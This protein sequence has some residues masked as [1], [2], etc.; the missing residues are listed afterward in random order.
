MAAGGEM[1]GKK[2]LK[3]LIDAVLARS[4]LCE[5]RLSL[6][7]FSIVKGWHHA[8]T[9]VCLSYLPLAR[10]RGAPRAFQSGRPSRRSAPRANGTLEGGH[11][12]LSGY[13][14]VGNSLATL[15]Q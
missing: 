1:P 13:R 10:C 4:T 6:G 8:L 7:F 15:H 2:D 11:A 9:V 3:R 12:P 14:Y 5:L